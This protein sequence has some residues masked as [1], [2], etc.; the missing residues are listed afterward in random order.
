CAHRNPSLDMDRG[1]SFAFPIRPDLRESCRRSPR[2]CDSSRPGSL[3]ACPCH[4]L[5][6]KVGGDTELA[7]QAADLIHRQIAFSVEEVRDQALAAEQGNE[8]R[9]GFAL[10]LERKEHDLLW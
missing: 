2:R 8:I 6:E 10:L 4:G 5:Q 3:P 7:D 9:S 1:R